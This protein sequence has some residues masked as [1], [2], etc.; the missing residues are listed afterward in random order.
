MLRMMSSAN[1]FDTAVLKVSLMAVLLLKNAVPP[2][3]ATLKVIGILWMST[4]FS[5][6]S[7]PSLAILRLTVPSMVTPLIP[8]LYWVSFDPSTTVNVPF[9]AL[10]VPAE[11]VMSLSTNPGTG[12]SK[13]SV[14]KFEVVFFASPF[15]IAV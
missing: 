15:A 7:T 10:A 6:S 8:R 5:A 12:S 2:M 13:T 1:R 9:V 14:I 4:I 3:F 11:M